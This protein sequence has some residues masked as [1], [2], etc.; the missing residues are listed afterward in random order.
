VAPSPHG[1][2]AAFHQF[3]ELPVVTSK[4]GH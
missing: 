1:L 2:A 3:N 4:G